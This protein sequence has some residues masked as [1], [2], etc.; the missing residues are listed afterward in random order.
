MRSW[1]VVGLLVLV[2]LPA[3]GLAPVAPVAPETCP[4]VRDPSMLPVPEET[5]AMLRAHGFDMDV[6]EAHAVPVPYALPGA[7]EGGTDS[8]ACSGKIR[9]GAQLIIEN[10]WLCSANF[11]Y[12]DENDDFYVGTAGHCI[13]AVRPMSITISGVGDIGDP[14]FTTGN[15]GVGNDFA[16]IKVPNHL[17]RFVEPSMCHWGGP[18]QLG[19]RT[20]GGTASGNR[21]LV[22]YGWGFGYSASSVSRARMGIAR[23][24]DWTP[25]GVLNFQGTIAGGDSGSGIQTN[26]GAA[27]G[28]IT[29]TVVVTGAAG[30]PLGVV[31]GIAM[32]VDKGLALANAATGHT[33]E[34]YPARQNVD[35][36][37]LNTPP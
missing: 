31:F 21:V 13:D 19:S 30:V 35:L 12:V 10:A 37:G 3:A 23:G 18:V 17:W 4:N 27:A 8:H 14:V 20:D 32:P 7:L 26:Y 9:P 28:V 34:L 22:H 24:P 5:L 6:L 15:G 29:H 2:A 36:T 25:S 1:A 16:L 33:F 11:I